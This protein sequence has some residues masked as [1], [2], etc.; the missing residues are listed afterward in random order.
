LIA[1]CI[2]IYP[3]TGMLS[4]SPTG[5]DN[6]ADTDSVEVTAIEDA[7][8]D[9]I[10]QLFDVLATN[11]GDMP[12]THSTE[13]QCLDMFKAGLSN[14]KKARQLALAIVGGTPSV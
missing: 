1:I 4:A 7:Y 10:H 3:T 13:Q 14:A 8:H 12:V 6:L 11:L 2:A 9:R 5:E